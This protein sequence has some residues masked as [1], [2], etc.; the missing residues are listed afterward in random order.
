MQGI[1][2]IGRV[3]ILLHRGADYYTLDGLWCCGPN[4]GRDLNSN[5]CVTISKCGY[6]YCTYI[7]FKLLH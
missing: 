7:L 6:V 2:V 1:N 4:G 3:G 5:R